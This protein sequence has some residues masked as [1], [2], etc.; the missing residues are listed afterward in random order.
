MGHSRSYAYRV[1]GCHF[2]LLPAK[3]HYPITLS[4]I[5]NFF[6]FYMPVLSGFCPRWNSSF[7]KTLLFITMLIRVHKFTNL[8]TI[9]GD[10]RFNFLV[11]CTHIFP[12][13]IQDWYAQYTT[14]IPARL[15]EKQMKGGRAVLVTDRLKN[16]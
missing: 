10:E 2:K 11:M 16:Y 7:S 4:N 5:V 8:G 12:G 15:Q 3:M 9:F 6:G 14:K 13:E 1:P